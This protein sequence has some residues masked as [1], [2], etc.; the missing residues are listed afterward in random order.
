MTKTCFALTPKLNFK[1]SEV[2]VTTL[3]T[4]THPPK[5]LLSGFNSSLLLSK[6]VPREHDL[7]KGLSCGLFIRLLLVPTVRSCLSGVSRSS[8]KERVLPP[9]VK[10]DAEEYIDHNSKQYVSQDAPKRM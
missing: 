1:N 6:Q 4:L 5:T 2:K 7:S 3:T 8:G 10:M 9:A